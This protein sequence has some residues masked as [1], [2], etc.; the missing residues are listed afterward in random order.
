MP[1]YRSLCLF[2]AREE[3][4]AEIQN[5]RSKLMIALSSL[6]SRPDAET[7][8]F[9]GAFTNQVTVAS[10]TVVQHRYPE[11]A[12]KEIASSVVYRQDCPSIKLQVPHS[13]LQKLVTFGPRNPYPSESR[14]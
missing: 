10:R 5:S 4:L 11:E 7:E 1:D 9:C 3:P 12:I 13:L 14:D 6:S 8:A 2:L